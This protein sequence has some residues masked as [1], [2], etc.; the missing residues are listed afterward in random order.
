MADRDVAARLA[1]KPMKRLGLAALLLVIVQGAFGAGRVK[2]QSR[3]GAAR[4]VQLVCSAR[5]P[6]SEFARVF[7][8]V[9]ARDPGPG[10]AGGARVLRRAQLGLV[11]P[12]V[13]RELPA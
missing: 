10:D 9:I 6:E 8:G 7:M 12:R 3:P 1:Q 13:Q 2:V 4:V 11:A 5:A